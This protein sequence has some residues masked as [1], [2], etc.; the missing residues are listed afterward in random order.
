MKINKPFWNS[1]IIECDLNDYTLLKLFE[2]WNYKKHGKSKHGYKRCIIKEFYP[3][4]LKVKTITG[5]NYFT[6][7]IEMKYSEG[8][9]LIEIWMNMITV[10]ILLILIPSLLFVVTFLSETSLMMK[11]CFPSSIFMVFFLILWFSSRGEIPNL[12]KDI[13]VILNQKK[14]SYKRV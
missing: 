7:E 9:I 10:I 2:S 1:I 14:F 4:H 13:D 3:N 8:K 5:Y 6:P 11:I 12:Y